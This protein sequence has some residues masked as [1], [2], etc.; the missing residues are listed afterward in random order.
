MARAGLRTKNNAIENIENLPPRA[1]EISSTCGVNLTKNEFQEIIAELRCQ[2]EEKLETIESKFNQE[3]HELKTKFEAEL[4]ACRMRVGNSTI[5]TIKDTKSMSDEDISKYDVN[6]SLEAR[7][8]ETRCERRN[9]VIVHNVVHGTERILVDFIESLTGNPVLKTFRTGNK[10]NSKP[11][12]LVVK[13]SKRLS[14][15]FL[16][17]YFKLRRERDCLIDRDLTYLQR[18]ARSKAAKSNPQS[19][20]NR[21]AE[22]ESEQQ[23][24]PKSSDRPKAAKSTLHNPDDRPAEA[25]ATRP[26]HSEVNSNPRN[27]TLSNQNQTYL[28][29]QPLCQAQLCLPAEGPRYS[30]RS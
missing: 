12:P 7:E 28:R 5:K 26:F 10:T 16:D 13:T 27:V 25:K 21:Q 29:I 14:D 24:V 11:K 15:R 17:D 30:F 2:F 9:Q 22:T 18:L 23:R 20:D 4:D 1:N 6:L 19:P 8:I 3:L